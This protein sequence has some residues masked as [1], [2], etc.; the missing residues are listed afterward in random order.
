[1]KRTTQILQRERPL[2]FSLV[3]VVLAL[4]VISVAIVAI[5]GLIPIGLQTGHSSQDDTRAAQ[6][7]QTVLAGMA[8]QAQTAFSAVK[9]PVLVGT[10]PS[11]DLTTSSTTQLF[12]N[13]NGALLQSAAGATYNV[14]I[15]SDSNVTSDGFDTG[16]ANKV[17]VQL[18]WP[19]DS[20][21]GATPLPSQTYRDFVRIISKY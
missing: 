17:T 14:T 7:A 8:S 3:E 20:N 6:I 1:V 15:I 16:F 9:V 2:G 13:N 5:L 4:G 10:A 12:A 18:R 19:A 11:V 21:P